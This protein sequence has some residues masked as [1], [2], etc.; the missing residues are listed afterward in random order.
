VK[1]ELFALGDGS[2][3]PKLKAVD[4]RLTVP[5]QRIEISLLPEGGGSGLALFDVD[6]DGFRARTEKGVDGWALVFYATV[7]P[8][9][10][11][12]LEYFVNW[13]TQCRFLTFQPQQQ[14]MNFDANAEAES[15]QPPRRRAKTNGHDEA[16]A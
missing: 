14:A 15:T 6:V 10:R 13:Y 5:K 3:R 16:S 1:A 12:E 8:V 7:G 11:E 2:P 4:F 9:G